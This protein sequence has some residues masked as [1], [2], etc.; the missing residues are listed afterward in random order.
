MKKVIV[1]VLASIL[2]PC[3]LAG[4][5][6]G[7]K[8]YVDPEQTIGIRTNHEFVIV[9]DSNP[10][11]GYNWEETHD[12]NVLSLVEEK[13]DRDEKSPGLIGSGG[14]QYFRFKALKPSKTELTVIYK[15]SWE[16]EIADQKVFSVEIK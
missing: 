10:T 6:S 2:T 14:T 11:T 16:T 9:L 8:T 12:S 1:L 15:R 5:G 3:L 13:Y 4:C 7:A